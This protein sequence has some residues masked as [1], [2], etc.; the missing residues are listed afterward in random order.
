MAWGGSADFRFGQRFVDLRDFDYR[1]F[2]AS[3]DFEQDRLFN[4][5]LKNE[6]EQRKET[7]NSI[8]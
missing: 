3:K 7:M 8:Q 2:Y 6:K 4:A 5:D 1:K